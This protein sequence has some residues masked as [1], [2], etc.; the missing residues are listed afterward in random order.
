MKQGGFFMQK[1]ALAFFT[2]FSLIL[3]LSIYYI[4]LPK[5]HKTAL[6]Q[7]S[8]I[9]SIEEE[10]D[11]SKE[12]NISKNNEIVSHP[13]STTEE[14]EEAIKENEQLKQ[15][16]QMEEDLKSNIEKLGF[17][18]DIEIKDQT[19]YVYV[20][21][22]ENDDHASAILKNIYKTMGNSYFIEVSFDGE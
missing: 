9:A 12:T 11:E 20:H 18:S 5:E 2:M 16:K 13:D 17:K 14:K 15:Q 6:T 1:Q 22:K 21:E 4:T 7:E 10:I 3:M 8:V 19:I